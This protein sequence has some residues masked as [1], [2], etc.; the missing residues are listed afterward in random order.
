MHLSN[1]VET[2]VHQPPPPLLPLIGGMV[3]LDHRNEFPM[4]N[5]LVYVMHTR[6]DLQ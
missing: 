4:V 2:I 5:A 3:Y 1:L 6:Q